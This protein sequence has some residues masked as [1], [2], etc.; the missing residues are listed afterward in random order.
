[1][2]LSQPVRTMLLA[3]VL[4]AVAMMVR[5]HF[6]RAR[7]TTEPEESYPPPVVRVARDSRPT[8]VESNENWLD[9][10]P[11]QVPTE[12]GSPLSDQQLPVLPPAPLKR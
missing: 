1:M 9:T 11:Q 8:I 10:L 4:I 7:V 5:H 6:E 3:A 12:A 2:S